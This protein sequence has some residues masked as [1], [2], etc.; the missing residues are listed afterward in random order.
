MKLQIAIVIACLAG[1]V[2]YYSSLRAEEPRETKTAK[3]MREANSSI[4]KAHN[5]IDLANHSVQ[6][7]KLEKSQ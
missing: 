7:L 6:P 5:S 2:I 4:A 3:L 1:G